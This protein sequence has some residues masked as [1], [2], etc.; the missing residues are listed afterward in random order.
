[1]GRTAW[2]RSKPTEANAFSR[3]TQENP[4]PQ[5]RRVRRPPR[6]GSA[7]LLDDFKR[8]RA[9]S[10]SRIHRDQSGDTEPGG[11]AVLQQAGDGGAV[12]QGRQAGGEDDSPLLPSFPLKS[13]AAGI[14]PAGLQL[15]QF[16]A[17]A[18]VAQANRELVAD[19]LAA[20]AGEDGGTAGETCPL[21]LAAVGG[22]PSDETVVWQYAPADRWVVASR[23]IAEAVEPGNRSRPTAKGGV[24]DKTGWEGRGQQF[25]NL[26]WAMRTLCRAWGPA[27]KGK[28]CAGSLKGCIVWGC[29]EPKRKFRVEG[30]CRCQALMIMYGKVT[31]QDMGRLAGLFTTDALEPLAN[32]Y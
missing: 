9:V 20:A 8:G 14:E 29:W 5:H 23:G 22:E 6:A 17:A 32:R 7:K 15:G 27:P 11:S 24:S 1:M 3:C 16:V 18:G 10:A 21:L 13:S 31:S 19:Q 2:P 4:P 28:W 30:F 25:W 12:D 26:G